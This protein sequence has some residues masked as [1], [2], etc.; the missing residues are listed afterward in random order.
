MNIVGTVFAVLGV[1][2]LF[3]ELAERPVTNPEAHRAAWFLLGACV[4]LTLLYR[5]ASQ[6]GKE[7]K[8]R[9]APKAGA[10]RHQA[11]GP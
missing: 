9:P 10:S 11:R 3:L 8:G 7:S 1:Y 5:A 4:V 2:F 6:K